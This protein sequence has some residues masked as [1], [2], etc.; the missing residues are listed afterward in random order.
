MSSTGKGES[1][2]SGHRQRLRR[3]ALEVG[4]D[5]LSDIQALELMLN[6][7]TDAAMN[8]YNRKAAQ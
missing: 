4:V 3:T 5:K 8:E 2:H 7:E 1:I 6:D